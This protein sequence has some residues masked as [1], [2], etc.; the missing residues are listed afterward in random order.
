MEGTNPDHWLG[1]GHV[2][3][4]TLEDHATFMAA[5]DKDAPLPDPD[6]MLDFGCEAMMP[7][8]RGRR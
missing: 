3:P 1:G 8:A 5:L 4:G 6:G 7:P 2:V